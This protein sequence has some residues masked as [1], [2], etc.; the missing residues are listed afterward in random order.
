MFLSIG[1]SYLKNHFIFGTG[2]KSLNNPCLI[3]AKGLN[4]TIAICINFLVFNHDQKPNNFSLSQDKT[5]LGITFYELNSGPKL[6]FKK[7]INHKKLMVHQLT[8]TSYLYYLP[9]L[10]KKLLATSYKES[11]VLMG[12]SFF[13]TLFFQTSF[14]LL[15]FHDHFN[16][17]A[18]PF[19]HQH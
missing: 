5:N 17:R 11:V 7:V 16:A 6:S 2:Y 18:P 10:E 4:N 14:D 13:L 3:C 1:F 8:A 12:M 9:L 15:M 19:L